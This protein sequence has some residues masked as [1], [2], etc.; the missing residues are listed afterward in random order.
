MPLLNI[1][2]IGKKLGL[3]SDD[4]ILYGKDK[5]KIKFSSTSNLGKLI[6][7]TAMS[8]TPY[9]EGKTTVSIGLCDALNRLQKKAIVVLREPSMGPVFGMKGGA[10][11]GGKSQ[12]EPS[13]DINLH[14]TGDFHAIT[15]ANNLLCAA[16]DNHI[17]QGNALDIQ[18]VVF[19]RAVDVNDRALRSVELQNR[20]ENFSITAASE[21]MAL[22][23]FAQSLDDLKTRLGNI[24]I[25]YNSKNEMVYAKQL[26]IE[27][28]LT[29]LLKDAFLPNLVQTK[30]NNPAI[31]H[32]GPFAN[33]AHGCNSLV[34]TKLALSLGD[35][36][37]TEAG[38]GADLGAEKFYDMKCRLG[39]LKP[40]C[41]V[42]VATIKALKYHGGVVKEKIFEEDLDSLKKG[43]ANLER[44]YE[45]LKKFGKNIIICLNQYDTDL[46]SEIN[47]VKEFCDSRGISFSISSAY[48][49]GG[50]GAV[51]LAEEVLKMCNND[52]QFHY[53][54]EENLSVQQKI[55]LVCHEIYHAGKVEYSSSALEMIHKIE[56][57]NLSY[58]P[59]CVAKTQYSFSD[60]AKMIGAPQN[61]N[62]YVRDIC[63][64]HGAGFL[65]VLL[66]NIMTMPGLAKNPNYENID[67]KE[68]H[69]IG[70]K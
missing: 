12:V 40:D 44:H 55:E 20:E 22:F 31:I 56:K 11:G 65:T 37:V 10:T 63:L 48:L 69:I 61:F 51:G 26:K 57:E 67:V 15:A 23:C 42:L 19:H 33:I 30:E 16:I 6:L 2:E 60:D 64:Y 46:D 70:V 8:P 39:K 7:V 66:G 58:L 3:S 5:A 36:V 45:N 29:A 13:D 25:G 24:I 59:I 43:L 18:K 68:N 49:H 52:N 27:G 62:V 21:I 32:G 47:V 35:F 34:A 54:Y 41:T 14:F 17:Y 9:G 28:A 53:L 38:F 1:S 4:L 50:E